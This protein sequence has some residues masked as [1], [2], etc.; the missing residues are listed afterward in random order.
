MYNYRHLFRILLPAIIFIILGYVNISKV[1]SF[2][3]FTYIYIPISFGLVI[4]I[5]YWNFHRH[6]PLLG[7]FIGLLGTIASYLIG[8]LGIFLITGSKGLISVTIISPLLIFLLYGYLFRIPLSKFSKIVII[9]A[10]TILIV[11]EY[12]LQSAPKD[13]HKYLTSHK[14]FNFIQIWRIIIA[15]ALGIIVHQKIEIKQKNEGNK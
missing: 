4:G 14:I 11:Y 7:L 5:V 12:S 2:E 10:I 6:K 3:I 15:V 1:V 8:Y 13:V 9:I